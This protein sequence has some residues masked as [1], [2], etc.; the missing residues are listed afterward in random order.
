MKTL[1]KKYTA[2]IWKLLAPLG[3]WGVF[4]ISAV[5]AA[6]FGLPLDLV[7]SGYV[8][9]LL[10][11]MN[12]AG[13]PILSLRG[14][15]GLFLMYP[16]MA[17]VGS[18]LGSLFIYA[19]GRKG[20]EMVL[21]KRISTA[22]FERIRD[23]FEKQEFFALMIPSMLPP[24]TPFKLFVLSAGV[25]HMRVRDFLLAIVAGRLVRF[26]LLAGLTVWFGPHIVDTARYLFTE[27]RVGFW[28]GIGVLVVL[29]YVIYRLMRRPIQ[30]LTGGE[31]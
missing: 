22:R 1:L 23:R 25:F 27:H 24:P 18:A 26:I 28:I 21:R 17:A 11:G 10:Q 4:A 2:F 13:I 12:G 7:V 20:G 30:E 29:G 16:A 15:L 9:G 31:E 19:I 3:P 5:D 6:L 8:W 14:I